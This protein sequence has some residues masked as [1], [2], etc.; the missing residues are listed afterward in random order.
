MAVGIF[1]LPNRKVTIIIRIIVTLSCTVLGNSIKTILERSV[2]V[3]DHGP[4]PAFPRHG[5][6]P[7][8]ARIVNERSA[9]RRVQVHR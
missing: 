6:V 5:D 8:L 3:S 9:P 4:E 7:P 2:N 1:N